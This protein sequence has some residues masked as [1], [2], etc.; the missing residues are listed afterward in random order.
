MKSN[1][2]IFGAS[3]EG[4]DRLVSRALESI[5]PDAPAEPTVSLEAW[6]AQPGGRI[7][8]YKLLNVLGEGG[9]G[10]VY[11][12]AQETPMKREVA[13]KVVKPG[14]DTKQ[15]IAR[16]EA[17]R[18]ALAL[19]D[20][21][22]IARV[23]HAGTTEGG[24]PYFVMEL[25]AG[26]PITEH[27]DRHKLPIEERLHLFLQVCDA[28][29]HAHHKGIIHR[30]L[31]PSNI[32]V[33]FRENRT[34]PKIIDF[35]IAKALT[36]PLTERTLYTEQGQ[37]VGTP[38]YMSPEQAEVTGQGIDTRSDVY[39]LGVVLYELLTGV[40]PFDAQTL[41]EGGAEHIRNVL[42]E[43][44]PKTPST[45]L[46]TVSA[47][48]STKLA[49]QRRTDMR[50]LGRTLRGDLD[51]IT[52]KAME[53]D[54]NRRYDTPR[55][56]AE[57]IGRHLNHE[58]VLA[59]S[60]G[61]VYRLR[62]FVR[63]HRVQVAAL[64]GVGVLVMA[65]VTS[66]GILRAGLSKSRNAEVVRQ[67]S[68]LS[69]AKTLGDQGEY[70][71][72]LAA[73]KT[74]LDSTHV[75]PQ[76]RLLHARLLMLDL[77]S[78]SETVMANDVRWAQV[79]QE[80]Q[81]LLG[82]SDEIAGQAHFLLATIYYESD[83]EAPASTKGYG[84]RWIEHQ[85][86]ADELLPETADSYLLRAISAATVPQALGFLDQALKLDARHFES[87][88][89]RAYIHDVSGNYR[90]MA[91]DAEKMKT[92]K[93]EDA[94]GYL[95]SAMAQ[96]GLGWF[97]EA[98]ADHGRAL[99]LSPD[100]AVLFD[101][102]RQTYMGMGDYSHA[103]LDAR[104]CVRLEPSVNLYEMRV[105]FTLVALG[106]YEQARTA[107]HNLSAA[108]DFDKLEFDDW[109]TRHVFDT[110]AAG[111][112]WYPSEDMPTGK[113]FLPLCLADES[114]RHLAEKATR[115]IRQGSHPSF[116]PDGTKLAYAL[117][118]PQFTGIAVYDIES[119]QSQLLAIPGK[120]PAWSPDG[121]HIAYTRNRQTLPF[122][123]L[124]RQRPMKGLAE[125]EN[126]ALHEV[127]MIKADGTEPPR[128]IAKGYGP[129]WS[130]D[131]KQVIYH[132]YKDNRI[133]SKPREAPGSEP[134]P[135]MVRSFY[136]AA[137]SPNETYDAYPWKGGLRI[138][139]VTTQAEVQWRPEVPAVVV[140]WSPDGQSLLVACSNAVGGLWLYDVMSQSLSRIRKGYFFG[141]PQF[142][143]NPEKPRLVFEFTTQT[144]MWGQEIWMADLSPQDC[145]AERAGACHTV[146]EHHQEIIKSYYDR[147]IEMDPN[148]PMNY[149]LR[150]E[151]YLQLNDIEKALIDIEHFARI[152]QNPDLRADPYLHRRL[153]YMVIRPQFLKRPI[154]R[155]IA[156]QGESIRPDSPARN[157]LAWCYF[158]AGVW[159][160][161]EEGY[162]KAIELYQTATRI[163]PE[164]A[165]A[166]HHLADLQA[167]CQM[168]QLRAGSPAIENAAKACA[169]TGWT[170]SCYIET[171]AA[172]HANAGDFSAAV[173][174]QQEALTRLAPD[175]TEGRRA[176]AQA[177]LDLYRQKKA[178]QQQYLWPHR[179]IAWWKFE[180]DDRRQVRDHSGNDLHGRFVGNACI[181]SDPDRG[182]V[183]S[184]D[185]KGDF[186]DCGRDVR[187]DLTE[188]VSICAWIKLRV[189]N[190]KHQAVV[191]NGDRGWILNRQAYANG[192]QVA[193]YGIASANNPGSLWGHLPTQKEV[194]DG[195]WHHLVGVYDG[196]HLSLYVDG[197]L[198]TTCKATGRVRRN[199]W[200]VFIGENSEQTN[201]EWDG[202]IDDV[203]IYSY[204]LSAEEIRILYESS[205]KPGDTTK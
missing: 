178:Y 59:G 18:Q 179:L 162:G 49:N 69:A 168:P 48:E 196:T 189:L 167:T 128:F 17:E 34:V 191:S 170:N 129:W 111:L 97:T 165:V 94:Q 68:V 125:P 115:L 72:A 85:K 3:P 96:R 77:Q 122:S 70:Q 95:L 174:W 120:D 131:S 29:Q 155:L 13:L 140:N 78:S 188:T 139:D 27:C 50:T 43:K 195:Q 185:G 153:N 159:A 89:T 118:V 86:K 56:L 180:S 6:T 154:D 158:Y 116:S 124:S 57:D 31:K 87:V 30:D 175:E 133:Y 160:Q 51:W 61:L 40:L 201:R 184:L 127:W 81:G 186:V 132:S 102:R 76:A 119:R 161:R 103:L 14:M 152:E 22:N 150:A 148:E 55:A 197:E 200:P 82:E 105:F 202:L 39:S 149:L 52:L 75:G 172:A 45:R 12:A 151:R 35:G 16:F 71:D 181:V 101:E 73:V 145:R 53:K 192:M 104:E 19:L 91:L 109:A 79:I 5:E 143:P 63:R 114:Y 193:G 98:I 141:D 41:R 194:S 187:F 62:K 37:F 177:K 121:R 163:N 99:Q 166:Y 138:V 9:M 65:L 113:A 182:E 66:L 83:P 93:P 199:D 106:Q 36:Q 90:Q 67:E 23:Y 32:L 136:K 108:Y 204:A 28:V 137:I 24:R 130:R 74:I 80:L 146:A 144:T 8:D 7:G 147:S 134:T 38:E 60:P 4:L 123:V 126:V 1:D 203:R 84:A 100:N 156:A 157:G 135:I 205:N 42:R 92:I 58:P 15:V 164:L 46:R 54:P 20:H 25:V 110:L 171:Y 26:V 169:L 173:K 183:L 176:R 33:S 107:Y 88:K 198:D 2:S 64:L 47:E 142:S 21:P 117:G 11:R 10:V 44:N 112:S 190:K